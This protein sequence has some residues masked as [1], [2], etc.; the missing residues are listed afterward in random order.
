M[1]PKFVSCIRDA[2]EAKNLGS[3]LSRDG[4]KPMS[5]ESEPESR[6]ETGTE[7]KAGRD[8]V[9]GRFL[10]GACPNPAGR[11]KSAH[12][13]RALRRKLAEVDPGD[14]S[15]R[16]HAEKIAD[17]LIKRAEVG[18]VRAIAEIADRTEGKARQTVEVGSLQT[19]FERMTPEELRRYAETGELP[20]WFNDVVLPPAPAQSLLPASEPRQSDSS[21]VVDAEFV[22]APN[23]PPASSWLKD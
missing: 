14:P 2:I 10:P 4:A 8:P 23:E 1:F 13:S 5:S 7:A 22:E 16:S 18:D 19:R 11:P 9:T 20:A 12:L 17:A 3:S 6:V 15:A 21:E